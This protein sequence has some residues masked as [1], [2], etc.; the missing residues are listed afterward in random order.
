MTLEWQNEQQQP[1]GRI[2]KWVRNCNEE[3]L[4]G[5]PVIKC[6]SLTINGERIR[7]TA[8]RVA[9]GKCDD[10]IGVFVGRRRDLIIEKSAKKRGSFAN[11]SHLSVVVLL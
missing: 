11:T 5:D 10:N 8:G 4:T 7:W 2:I 1:L 9:R 6:V 3:Q